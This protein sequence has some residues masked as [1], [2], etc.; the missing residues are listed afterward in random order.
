MY[1]LLI[2]R[3]GF[4]RPGLWVYINRFHI[5]LVMFG[6]ALLVLGMKA[7]FITESESLLGALDFYLLPALGAFSIVFGSRINAYLNR[8]FSTRKKQ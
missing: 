7:V 3:L 6:I 1:T 2:S 8:H 5:M 4:S